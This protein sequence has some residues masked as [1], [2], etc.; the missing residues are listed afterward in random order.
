[1]HL[2]QY[3]QKNDKRT[4]KFLRFLNRKGLAIVPHLLRSETPCETHGKLAA[5]PAQ[6]GVCLYGC[7]SHAPTSPRLRPSWLR[8]AYALRGF[9]GQ[10]CIC[11]TLA[12]CKIWV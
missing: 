1:M 3:E 5:C 8:R 11:G 2:K 4:G 9:G 12:N 6:S 7:V 10:A